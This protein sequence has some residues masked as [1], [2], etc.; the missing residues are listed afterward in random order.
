MSLSINKLHQEIN[1]REERKKKV[2]EHILILSYKRIVAENKKHTNCCCIFACPKYVYGL[3]LYNITSCIIYIMEDL[4]LKGFKVQYLGKNLIYIDWKVNPINTGKKSIGNSSQSNIKYDEF[5][6]I[7][8]INK[9]VLYGN[10]K[11][12]NITYQKEMDD[13]DYLLNNL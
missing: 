11:P 1:D 6:D 5:R 7:M 9:N 4:Q 8:D 13:L 2:Y 12:E 3:P 10:T